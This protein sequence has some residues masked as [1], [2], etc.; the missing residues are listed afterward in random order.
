[1]NHNKKRY[2]YD[3]PLFRNKKWL[4]RRLKLLS[5]YGSGNTNFLGVGK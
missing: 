2:E 3:V 1:M 5:K 4:A